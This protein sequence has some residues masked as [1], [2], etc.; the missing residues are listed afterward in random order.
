MNELNEYYESVLKK[1]QALSRYSTIDPMQDIEINIKD[2]MRP[3]RLPTHKIHKKKA[4]D[5]EAT[6]AKYN[7]GG[8]LLFTGGGDGLVRVWDPVSGLEK[9]TLRGANQ[10]ILDLDVSPGTELI[11]AGC[12]DNKVIVW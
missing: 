4:H 2:T 6:C 7:D 8:S 1:E 10:A 3:V 12:V 11:A 5:E 9:Q